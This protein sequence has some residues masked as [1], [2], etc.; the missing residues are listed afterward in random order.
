MDHVKMR[1]R[2]RKEEEE[3]YR[4]AKESTFGWKTA[5][6][7]MKDPVFDDEDEFDEDNP[8]WQKPELS[9]E[10]K[11]EKLKAKKFWDQNSYRNK[12]YPRSDQSAGPA[13]PRLPYSKPDS[14]RCHICQGVGHIMRFCPLRFQTNSSQY[15][16][17]PVQSKVR[18]GQGLNN[19]GN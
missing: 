6:A 12:Y 17:Q 16:Q 8:W 11:L 2:K 3:S 4:I 19:N 15:G 10:K 1:L 18:A 7:Y 14:R 5:Q 13:K 9:K